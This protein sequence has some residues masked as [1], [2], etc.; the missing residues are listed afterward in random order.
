MVFDFYRK[1]EDFN[2]KPSLFVYRLIETLLPK[3]S[4]E[5]NAGKKKLRMLELYVILTAIIDGRIMN[6]V[7]DGLR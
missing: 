1:D 7:R 3:A 6:H 5:A 4:Y 2:Y